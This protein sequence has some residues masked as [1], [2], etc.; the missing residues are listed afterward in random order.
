[1]NEWLPVS[2]DR[3]MSLRW[4]KAGVETLQEPFFHQS[5]LK[6]RAATPAPD[7]RETGVDALGDAGC[8]LTDIIP[9]GLIFHVS[10][11]GSTLLSN[12]LRIAENVVVISESE[13]INA[14][15][16]PS[17][18]NPGDKSLWLRHLVRIYGHTREGHP[19]NL[20][21]KFSSWNLL[22]AEFIRSLWPAVSTAVVF[23]DPL[24]VAVSML[25]DPPGWVRAGMD[26]TPIASEEYC[27]RV[28]ACFYEE[29]MRLVEAGCTPIHYADLNPHTIC[30]VAASFGCVLTSGSQELRNVL[31][32]YAK[33]SGT[34]NRFEPDGDRKVR[35]ASAATREA[36]GFWVGDTYERLKKRC[37]RF[38]V[39]QA[40]NGRPLVNAYDVRG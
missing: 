36:I 32:R 27:A 14:L 19:R 20:I 21:I 23:R 24:E 6:L 10:R 12:A 39:A 13:L 11:C 26:S 40:G 34:G 18:A 37:E 7:E 3:S 30:R 17:L 28:L 31:D 22:Y 25:A 16:D 38:V 33:D 15:L 5:V 2:L 9:G 4:I 8:T 35:S 29:A 1:M